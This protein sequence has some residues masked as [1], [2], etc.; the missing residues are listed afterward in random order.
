MNDCPPRDCLLRYLNNHLNG[1]ERDQLELHVENCAAC[2]QVLEA[3]TE[4]TGQGPEQETADATE[5]PFGISTP[6]GSIATA[7][8]TTMRVP[9]VVADT[10]TIVPG[11]QQPIVDVPDTCIGPYK[12]LEKIGEGG[13]GAVY[14]AM[15]DTPVRR[16]VALK[17]I[18]PGMDSAQVIAR[19]EAERQ[20]LALMDHPNIA[21]VFDAG[22]TET[23]RLF[24]V[25][26]RVEGIPI[27][28]YCD[29]ARLTTTQRLELFIPVCLAIQHAHQKGVIHRDIKPSNVLV[30]RVDGEAVP[31]VIDFGVAKAIDQRLTE[32]T[33]YTQQGAIV[34]TLEYMSPEQADISGLDIDTR[35]DVYALGVVLYELLAG[36]TPLELARLRGDGFTEI[37]RRIKEEEPPRP[38]AA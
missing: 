12:L 31:K 6:A 13:M 5:N 7:D 28:D 23:G 3:L 10:N 27:I 22:T 30:T 20:A 4:N 33:L 24:F 9:N 8:M 2:Q 35:S 36:S 38:S 34:G 16:R 1:T 32:K 17:M 25:M 14:L 29:G 37:L 15:Q 21:K 26:E 19:F 18:K 11:A